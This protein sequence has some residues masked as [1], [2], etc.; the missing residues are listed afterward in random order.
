MSLHTEL[1]TQLELSWLDR[2]LQGR[3]KTAWHFTPYPKVLQVWVM[4]LTCQKTLIFMGTVHINQVLAAYSDFHTQ[5]S[6]VSGRLDVSQGLSHVRL[7]SCSWRLHTGQRRE[8]QHPVP[9]YVRER[10]G[11]HHKHEQLKYS[12]NWNG[13]KVG[14]DGINFIDNFI[15]LYIFPFLHIFFSAIELIAAKLKNKRKKAS[16]IR[17][18]CE[19]VFQ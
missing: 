9:P 18:Y 7:G 3:I 14:G 16:M 8:L 12:R 1:W 15:I 5:F 6:L 19:C 11:P 17:Y 13:M 10:A 2:S 4:I